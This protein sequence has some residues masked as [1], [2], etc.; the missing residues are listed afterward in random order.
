MTT[1]QYAGFWRRVGAFFIDAIIL[2]PLIGLAYYFGEKS[3]LFNLYWFVPGT[4][5]GLWFSVYLVARYGGTPGKLLLKIR[6]AMLDG[7]PVTLKAAMIRHSVLF[8]LGVLL[9]IGLIMPTLDMPDLLYFSLSYTER[10]A[11]L[12]TAAPFWYFPVYILLN[13]WTWG[14]FISMLFNEKRR[15]IHD[16]MAGTVVVMTNPKPA[17]PNAIEYV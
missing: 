5:L 11:A 1:L 12:V 16:F 8:V 17:S 13:L 15:A 14:E 6:V 4:I 2:S 9:S 10:N 3:R 7:S